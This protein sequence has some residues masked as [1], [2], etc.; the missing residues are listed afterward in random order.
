M[1]WRFRTSGKV[2]STPAVVKGL[3]VF[4]SEGGFLHAVDLKTGT[5]AWK[6][7][8]GGDVS[9]SPA[10]AGDEVVILGPDGVLRALR[11]QDGQALWTLATG[12]DIPFADDPRAFDLFVS[13]PTLAEGTIF[14]GGGDGKVYA[15]DLATGKA[16]WSHATGHRVRSSPAVADGG[17]F[18]GS[19]DGNVYLPRCR[20]GRGAL[21]PRRPSRAGR[22]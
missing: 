16:R 20:D 3:A 17:V 15:V 21:S 14:V 7:R 1:A 4:G 5:A 18:V 10:I 11:L 6:V 12:R 22:W 2:R 9:G 8:I 13:S 19:F